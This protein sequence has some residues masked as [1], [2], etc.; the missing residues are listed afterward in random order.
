MT[1]PAVKPHRWDRRTYERMVDAGFFPPHS[2]AE[3]INGEI[4]DMSPQ[5]TVH[6]TVLSLLEA[7]LRENFDAG[8]L[9]RTQAP[10]IVSNDSEPEP[11][12]AVVTGTPRDYLHEH[13]SKACLLVEISDTTLHFDRETKSAMYAACGIPEYWLVNL[14]ENCVEVFRQPRNGRYSELKSYFAGDSITPLDVDGAI[15]VIG[16]LP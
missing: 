13:P 10:F 7:I 4:I 1:N 8:Y 12:I 9:I 11:D 16:F 15:E 2:H 14:K 5:G 3:L 6:Y